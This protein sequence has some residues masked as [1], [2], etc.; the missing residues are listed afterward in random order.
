MWVIVYREQGLA[1][2]WL[3]AGGA[4]F[5]T[6]LASPNVRCCRNQAPRRLVAPGARVHAASLAAEGVRDSAVRRVIHVEW[7]ASPIRLE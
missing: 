4:E 1:C 7:I 2:G 5:A 6:P 3:S